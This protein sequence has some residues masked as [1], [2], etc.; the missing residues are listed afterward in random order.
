MQIMNL[1]KLAKD[2]WWSI[3]AIKTINDLPD[4]IVFVDNSGEVKHYNRKAQ[5]LFGLNYE[6][7]KPVGFDEIVKDGMTVLI[8]AA[9]AGKPVLATASIP[10]RDFYIEMNVS[11]SFGGYTISIRDLT[12]MTTDIMNDEK[13]KV[14]NREKNAM[15]AKLEGDIKSP[16]TSISGFSRGL[17]DGIGGELTEKQEKYVKIINN[18]SE[19]LYHFMD[20]F[21]EFSK[22]ESS[23]YESDYHNF[24]IIEALKSI[25]KDLEQSIQAKGL[26]FD[27]DYDSIDKRTVYTD[28][29]S[30]KNAIRNILEVAISMTDNGYISV[31][32]EQPNEDTCYKFKINPK[33]SASY[34]QI[35]IQDTGVGVSED[36]L[37]YLCEPYAQLTNGKKNLLR[38][39]QLGSATIM[40]KRVVGQID[41]RSEVMHGTKY[42]ILVPIDKNM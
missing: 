33:K 11:K 7:F 3:T 6:E 14:F 22:A 24:D 27:I 4:A 38:A 5:E 23:I 29:N 41:I 39:L 37:R 21:L 1:D 17:L 13:T 19:E 31:K 34:I 2:L 28:V 15:L 40:I 20:K 36:D 10:G 26:A 30:I 25:S 12:K 32:L 35:T 8:N 16:I 42:T 18:N 9:E